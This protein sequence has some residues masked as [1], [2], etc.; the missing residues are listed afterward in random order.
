MWRGAPRAGAPPLLALL[1]AVALLAGAGAEE[2]DLDAIMPPYEANHRDAYLCTTVPL[3]D[4]QL[5]LIGIEPLSKQD[6]V[7]HML[8]FGERGGAKGR[9]ERTRSKPCETASP[10]PRHKHQPSPHTS[11]PG[12]LSPSAGRP[13]PAGCKEPAS[14]EPVFDCLMKSACAG[15]GESVL[16]GWGKNAP[17]MAL[18]EGTG[19]SVGK[20]TGITSLVL[21]VGR[22]RGGGGARRPQRELRLLTGAP[23]RPR[24]PAKRWSTERAA[25]PLPIHH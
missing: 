1:A 16:Y 21:Q 9:P 23:P 3:P 14:R 25:R 24:P 15:G 4:R 8:L 6:V 12:P 20:G 2:L 11:Q 7:H 19:F 18:P 17:K 13:A 10:Q 22:R 5:K